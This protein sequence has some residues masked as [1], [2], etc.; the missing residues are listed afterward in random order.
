MGQRGPRRDVVNASVPEG[1]GAS[2][3]GGRCTGSSQ[4]EE[5]IAHYIWLWA[6]A[7]AAV[8]VLYVA[9]MLVWVLRVV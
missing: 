8:Y 7:L 5:T 9:V 3:R 6:A 4:V 2:K 1:G